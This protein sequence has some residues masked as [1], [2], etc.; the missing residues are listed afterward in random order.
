M[1]PPEFPDPEFPDEVS[2][3]S[4]AWTG[5]GARLLLD[6]VVGNA[7][8]P[9]TLTVAALA[10]MPVFDDED[11]VA[12]LTGVELLD[13]VSPPQ[14]QS[15]GYVRSSITVADFI[16]AFSW[17]TA[18]TTLS[19]EVSFGVNTGDSDWSEVSHLAVL[20]GTDVLAIVTLSTPVT[21]AP[22]YELRVPTGQFRLL[23]STFSTGAE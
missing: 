21:N 17:N 11:E 16:A 6:L 15:S 18:K 2:G 14:I 7:V 5:T 3:W 9:T 20:S 23:A 19:G 1:L 12:S 10:G 4:C 8:A 22:D 13:A